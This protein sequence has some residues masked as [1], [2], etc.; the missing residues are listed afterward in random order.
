M[1]RP[2]TIGL[3]L[4]VLTTV[5]LLASSP[6]AGQDTSPPPHDTRPADTE[7]ID[8]DEVPPLFGGEQPAPDDEVVHQWAVTPA[9]ADA[10]SGNRSSLIYAADPGSTIRDAITVYNYSNVSLTF[11]I[12]ATDAFNNDDGQFALLPGDEQP[13]DVGSWAE[14]MEEF[15]T[16]P[17]G[18][19]ATVPVT[20][21]IPA[22]ALPGDH[23][24]AIVAASEALSQGESGEMVS[25]ERRTGTRLYLRVNGPLTADLAIE[26][27]TTDYDAS[28]NPFGGSALVSYTIHNRGNIRLAG[29]SSVSIAAPIGF[30]R[31]RTSPEP[32]PEL[33]PGG[34]IT[35]QTSIEDAPGLVAAFTT[36]RVEPDEAASAGALPAFERRS[37]TFTPPIGVLL[38]LTALLLVWLALRAVRR[39]R[40]ADP[41]SAATVPAVHERSPEYEPEHQPT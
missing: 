15:V 35:I 41:G 24:G 5:L 16:L 37:T 10:T 2:R 34:T 26:R 7:P 38:L 8:V 17:P 31:Q 11:R 32:F 27:L 6:A 14:P 23:A 21:E 20:I 13:S 25:L 18:L 30:A 3:G 36:V 40:H 28:F 29:S 12:Y 33:L 19:Q 22:G 4:A 39:H 9:A 1:N